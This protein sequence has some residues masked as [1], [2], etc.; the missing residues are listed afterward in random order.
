MTEV[1]IWSVRGNGRSRKLA[2]V[3]LS[4]A[5]AA[6]DNA[7]IYEST[8]YREP[9]G[10]VAA[11]YAYEK[12]MPQLMQD[13]IDAGKTVVFLDLGFWGRSRIRGHMIPGMFPSYHKIAINSRHPGA[14][15]MDKNRSGERFKLF[16]LTVKEWTTRG[17]HIL[18][19]GMSGRAAQSIGYAPEEWERWAI[20]ELKKHTDRPI[21]YRPKPT[22]HDSTDIA[23]ATR[24]IKSTISHALRRAHAVVTHHSNVAI[25]GIIEG[26]PAFCFDGVAVPMTSQD[27]SQIETPHRPDGREQ[28]LA[29]VAWSQFHY[30]EIKNGTMWKH[31]KAEGLIP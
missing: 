7:T 13:Y 24:D 18:I 23:G 3:I 26:V 17:N 2:P 28:W 11:F 5:N 14:Y 8:E 25:D 27:L 1:A 15:V 22:W 16:D 29:N 4:G 9:I 12:N 10:D 31:L 21:I 19:A 30:F 6:G 20:S